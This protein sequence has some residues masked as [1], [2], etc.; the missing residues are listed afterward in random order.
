ML[1]GHG[2]M[3]S[4]LGYYPNPLDLDMEH[5]APVIEPLKKT[6]NAA[7]LLE[8]PMAG[9]FI[10]RRDFHAFQRSDGGYICIHKPL[11]HAHLLAH[12]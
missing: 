7:A 3:I 11:E 2:L 6:I 5:R 4:S 12:L 9:I 10:G 8:V 1:D